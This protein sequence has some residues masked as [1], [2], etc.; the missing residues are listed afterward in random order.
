[1][2]DD[3]LVEA[4][5]GEALK[6]ISMDDA[7]DRLTALE[8]ERQP[9]DTADAPKTEPG[10]KT[11]SDET[12]KD[13]Q[14][15][16]DDWFAYD[17]AAKAE[18]EASETPETG[19]FVGK[20]A[21]VKLDDG[22]VASVDDLIRGRML[23]SDYSRKTEAAAE[24]R[25]ANEARSQA[26]QERENALRESQEMV[27]H[28]LTNARPKPPDAEL[29]NSDPMAWIQQNAF[30]QEQE[31]NWRNWVDMFRQ[32]AE[33]Q[34]TALTDEQLASRAENQ[35]RE[36]ET[37]KE[38]EPVF[39]D[40][41]KAKRASED[42]VKLLVD[43]YGFRQDEVLNVNGPTLW[44]DHRYVRVALDAALY[45]LGKDRSQKALAAQ[46][47]QRIPK[48]MTPGARTAPDAAKSA[49]INQLSQ[50]LKK[51]GSMDDAI[52]LIMAKGL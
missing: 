10:A 12:E 27:I 17:A 28:F 8:R 35:R 50:S 45:R 23:Q 41:K 6:P 19:Q 42:I 1:M 20:T 46:A 7:L 13:Q 25:K 32:N 40:A 18:A 39:A 51:T 52:N 49:Q 33:K 31:A 2:A 21:K 43:H 30:F 16:D 4:G 14:A 24:M 22:T 15:A 36:Y 37:L 11:S 5:T 47:S 9:A 38:K 3:N 34:K 26:L 44:D 48:V 29:A